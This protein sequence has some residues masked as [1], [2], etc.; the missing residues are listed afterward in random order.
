[1]V[2]VAVNLPAGSRA[3]RSRCS[4][5][6]LRQ[7]SRRTNE[8]RRP[9]EP[10]CTFRNSQV[11]QDE[12]DGQRQVRSSSVVLVRAPVACS[13]S[14]RGAR[15]AARAD[16]MHADQ[17]SRGSLMP[18]GAGVIDGR[19]DR[20]GPW[21]CEA[22]GFAVGARHGQ[23]SDPQASSRRTDARRRRTAEGSNGCRFANRARHQQ[24]NR[25]GPRS[26][27][28]HAAAP[29]PPLLPATLGREAA[30]TVQSR[31]PG[32]PAAQRPAQT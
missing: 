18:E 22:W 23:Q 15:S 3:A 19:W 32:R 2:G 16:R 27:Q 6:S 21:G 24:Q 9:E 7:R 28:H 12:K 17:V 31:S 29:L 4:S 13:G 11:S 30:V 14:S 1:M 5:R 20:P 25:A 26:G 8:R 10:E